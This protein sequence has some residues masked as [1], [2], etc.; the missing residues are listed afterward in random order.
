M[1]SAHHYRE[2]AKLCLKS[3]YAAKT[4][5]EASTF[6]DLARMSLAEAG[7]CELKS[8]PIAPMPE[9]VAQP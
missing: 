4:S 9:D 3:A 1:P 5:E 8:P 7:Q 6:F 2:Y